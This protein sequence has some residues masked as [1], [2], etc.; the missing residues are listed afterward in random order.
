MPPSAGI[1][2]CLSFLFWG[3]F[4]SLLK[5]LNPKPQTPNPKPQTPNPKPQNPN[6]KPQTPNPKPKHFGKPPTCRWTKHLRFCEGNF[7]DVVAETL[8]R[9]PKPSDLGF[10][11]GLGFREFLASTHP[12]P[13]PPPPPSASPRTKPFTVNPKP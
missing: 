3:G 7:Q 10:R 4:T 12:H 13:P 5:N 8:H 6:S 1:S 9:D 2:N 11:A